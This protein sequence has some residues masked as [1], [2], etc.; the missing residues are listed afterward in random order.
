MNSARNRTACK[1][2]CNTGSRS[3][4]VCTDRLIR[5]SK[6][7]NLKIPVLIGAS[8][9]SSWSSWEKTAT[10]WPMS[11]LSAGSFWKVALKHSFKGLLS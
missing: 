1:C 8:A 4:E 9:F 2:S 6:L 11:G 7:T 3:A 10:R 5:H